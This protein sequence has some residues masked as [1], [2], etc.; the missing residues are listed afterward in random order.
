MSWLNGTANGNLIPNMPSSGLA[1]VVRAKTDPLTGGI[2]PVAQGRVVPYFG[3]ADRHRMIE[4]QPYGITRCVRNAGKLI[5]RFVSTELTIEAG[6]P[7][8]ANHTGYDASGN[9]TGLTSI[10]GQPNM[11]K[12]T[13]AA[14][15]TEGFRFTTFG[16]SVFNAA[17]NGKIGLWMYVDNIKDYEPTQSGPTMIFKLVVTTEAGG[18]VGNAL[19][20]SWTGNQIREGWNFLTFVMRNPL[21]YQTGSGQTEYNPFGI[22]ATAYGTG[23]YGNIK[24][25]PVTKIQFQWSQGSGATIYLDSL[26]TGF[27]T[28]PQIVFGC[29]AASADFSAYARPVFDSY[30]WVGYIA[31]P[32][33]V[34]TTGSKILNDLSDTLT[35]VSVSKSIMQSAHAAGWDVINHTTNHQNMN[36]LTNAAEIAYEVRQVNAIY[37]SF[38]T[39]TG[40]EFYA[41]P[42][43]GSSRLSEKVI[44]GC[45]IK[46]QRHSRKT[47]VSVTPWGIDNPHYVGATDLAN[48]SGGCYAS[49]TSGVTSSVNGV[50]LYSK[51][52][53]IVDMMTDY[54]VTWFP[55]WHFVTTVGDSGSGEDSTGDS[56]YVTKSA[57]EKLLAYV[58]SLETAGTVRVCRGVTGFYYGIG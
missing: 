1:D 9:V 37:A 3:V 33:R 35:M 15:T 11:L 17:L 39:R 49:V 12:I 40:N 21:A 24:D 45:G 22:V 18:A 27:E 53:I 54:G 28:T 34:W 13:P 43:S 5:A 7:T 20:L 14:D 31:A 2:D 36:T 46:L 38:G 50:Q 48:I 44:K 41:S 26:W 30:G 10:T 57:F 55:F 8:L 6:S 51:M 4:D 25:N 52:K 47:N 58:K 56:L 42:A 23:V 19:D 29:D 16:T 32:A